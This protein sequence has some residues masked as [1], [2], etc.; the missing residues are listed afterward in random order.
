[1]LVFRAQLHHRHRQQWSL[2]WGPV[3]IVLIVDGFI[4]RL[5]IRAGEPGPSVLVQGRTGA[6]GGEKRDLQELTT[7]YDISAAAAAPVRGG[8]GFVRLIYGPK[9][10]KDSGVKWNCHLKVDGP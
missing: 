8:E 4:A 9:G 2:P 10:P 1:M 5:V 3:M 6:L 7:S